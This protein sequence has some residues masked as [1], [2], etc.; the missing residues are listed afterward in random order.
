MFNRSI[1]LIIIGLFLSFNVSSFE[2]KI[3]I[4]IDDEIIT[5]VDI[6][7]ETQYLTTLNKNIEKLSK[8]KVFSIAKNSLIKNKIKEKEIKK[9]YTNIKPDQ[10]FI[11][12][13]IKSNASKLGFSNLK[14][15]EKYLATYDLTIKFL[16]NKLMNEVLWNEL[17]VKK[18]SDKIVIDKNKI[19]EQIKTNTTKSK[20]Y[21][22]SEIIFNISQGE[23]LKEKFKDIENEILSK[24]FENAALIYSIS[25]TS[26]SGGKLGWI[27]ENSINKKIKQKLSAIK[28]NEYTKPIKI[29]GGFLILKI[30]NI[31]EREEQINEE[32]ELEKRIK[33]EEN[34][35]LSQFSIIYLNKI[36][37]DTEIN[38]Y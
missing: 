9:Y 22:L 14:D 2:N 38:E 26:S 31:D 24:G 20:S 10:K 34:Q 6:Y 32:K 4:K 8:E 18:Y 27:K 17:V 30:E 12:D 23:N 16:Q 13:I 37:K 11:N 5:T 19:K 33:A 21:L 36:K 3:L 28:I 29:S 35:Q 7:K 25:D 1:L 15:F